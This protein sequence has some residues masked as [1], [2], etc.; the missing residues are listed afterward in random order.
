MRYES[1]IGSE[2]KES[3]RVKVKQMNKITE[4]T[5]VLNKTNGFSDI[6][7]LSQEEYMVKST[8]EIL[9]YKHLENRA[10]DYTSLKD[11]FRKIRDLINTNFIGGANEIHLTLTYGENMTD[12]QKLY[13]DFKA[14]WKRYVRKYGSDIDYMTVVEPQG[15]GAWH[16][17]VLIRHN[18]CKKVFIPAKELETLWGKGFIKVKALK[19]VDNIGAYMSAYLADIEVNSESLHSIGSID[20]INKLGIKEALV[21]GQK[22]SFVKGGRLHMYPPGMNLYRHSKGIVYPEVQ[23]MYYKEAKK[24]VGSCTPNYSRTVKIYEGDSEDSRILNTVTYEQYNLVR[25]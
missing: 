5:H 23:E 18:D 11:S 8:G 13:N 4:I 17:H 25:K 15:R 9:Q 21:D 6:Q 10:Q 7:K 12:S 3:Y 14:F 22:K 16:T 19:G 1:T 24:I 2:I 20:E